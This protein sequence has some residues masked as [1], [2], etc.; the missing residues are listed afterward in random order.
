MCWVPNSE[1]SWIVAGKRLSDRQVLWKRMLKHFPR[2]NFPASCL[3]MNS[4]I[5]VPQS[6]R[7]HG[8]FSKAT[9]LRRNKS[10]INQDSWWWIFSS[11]IVGLHE[12][13]W[14]KNRPTM[15]PLAEHSECSDPI[16]IAYMKCSDPCKINHN[17][18]ASTPTSSSSCHTVEVQEALRLMD[19]F[20]CAWAPLAHSFVCR[21][22]PINQNRR[23]CCSFPKPFD[24]FQ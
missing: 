5:Y 22:S 9:R 19:W 16:D 15:C 23:R 12:S 7:A 11:I 20:S 4:T 2:M 21:F 8:A 24:G 3:S 14:K 6:S 1:R 18:L 10:N 17:K 13:F